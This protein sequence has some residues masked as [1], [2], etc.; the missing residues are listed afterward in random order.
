[1]NEFA[2]AIIELKE[3]Q[4]D[5]LYFLAQYDIEAGDNAAAKK[6]LEKAMEGR[7]SPLNYATREKVEGLLKTL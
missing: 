3:G 4:I 1:M 7:F 5:T 2:C 6:K